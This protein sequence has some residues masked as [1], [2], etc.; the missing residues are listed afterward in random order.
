VLDSAEASKVKGDGAFGVRGALTGTR[1]RT[2]PARVRL[3]ND[4]TLRICHVKQVRIDVIE[5]RTP[6]LAFASQ[7]KASLSW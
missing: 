3:G 2:Q 1:S 5:G 7:L 6:Q 4:W